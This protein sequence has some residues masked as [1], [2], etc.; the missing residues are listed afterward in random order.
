M[1]LL[2]DADAVKNAVSVIEK[3]QGNDTLLCVFSAMG[4]T[5]NALELAL[6]EAI[7]TKGKQFTE[8]KSEGN[9]S[10]NCYPIVQRF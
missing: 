3:F 7:E 1:E 9:A 10:F 6:R 5:T 4:K 2:K 8:R